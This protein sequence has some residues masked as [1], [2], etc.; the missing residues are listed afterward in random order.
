MHFDEWGYDFL[1]SGDAA[2]QDERRAEFI[3]WLKSQKDP[4]AIALNL[5]LALEDF[6]F[7]DW[8]ERIEYAGE[9]PRYSIWGINHERK[10]VSVRIED[11]RFYYNNGQH[12]NRSTFGPSP[13]RAGYQPLGDHRD[14]PRE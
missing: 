2:E 6:A 9:P 5:A 13:L 7:I 8:M 12:D 4:T 1:L 14:E 10:P 11:G 3:A